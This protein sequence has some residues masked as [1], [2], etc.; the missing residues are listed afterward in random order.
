MNN[1]CL[2][3]HSLFVSIQG[4]GR[5]SGYP[6]LFLRLSGCNLSCSWCDAHEAAQEPPREFLLPH[7][8]AARFSQVSI[9]DICITGGEPLLQEKA[10]SEML[11]LLPHN[12]RV[13][14]ETNGSLPIAPLRRQFPSLFFSVD[15]KT[16]SSGEH[17]SFDPSNLAV[18]GKTGWI[19]FVVADRNDLDFVAEH[20][21]NVLKHGV[22]IFVSPVF[23]KGPLWFAEVASFV[24]NFSL[25][26]R[27][28]IQIHKIVGVS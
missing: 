23:E 14:I 17:R 13:T 25:P 16:P 21:P 20:A 6:S 7:E 3:I 1:S 11:S 5:F 9:H 2:A 12:R 24:A 15:W 22:E 4:E 28:Q 19:K 10:L 26:L 18:I 8:V 27:L